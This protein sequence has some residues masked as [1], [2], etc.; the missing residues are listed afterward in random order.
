MDV[1]TLRDAAITTG[2]Q[3]PV[4]EH[5]H[6]EVLHSQRFV[7]QQDKALASSYDV[8]VCEC[9]GMAFADTPVTQ[10]EYDDLYARQSR[11]ASGP[12]AHA[13][14]NDR[15]SG[16]F[17]AVAADV[18]QIVSNSSARIV[19]IGC[20]NGQLLAALR[21]RGFENLIGVD[22]SPACV[23]AART[24]PSVRAFVGSL[25]ALP[26]GGG[27]YDVAVLSHVLEHVRDLGAALRLVAKSMASGGLLYV[28]VPDAS[29]YAE[30]AWS[31][32][33][34]FN[35]EHI[36]HFSLVSLANLLRRCGFR[37]ERSASKTILSAPGMPYPAISWFARCDDGAAQTIEPDRE[38][39]PRLEEYVRVSALLLREI[40]ARLQAALGDGRRTIVWGT[41]ELTA[42]LLADTALASAN[43]VAFVDSNPVNQ[44]KR[45]QGLPILAP[46]QVASSDDVIVVA[47]ILHHESILNAIRRQGLRNPVLTVTAPSGLSRAVGP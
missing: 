26:D 18:A 30:F 42:K 32:F 4:C 41:G 45:L 31:P 5:G 2:R 19:D 34:D 25:F 23:Q 20:A 10:R 29:R 22:P 3:C 37:P 12:A 39:K 8:V 14:D 1:T 6:A 15:D 35:S 27:T 16:R 36:N 47:S 11:Y 7:L 33:Q 21:E 28:E 46:G 38:L 17:R 43:I 24:I 9:C 44:G 40:D 13:A